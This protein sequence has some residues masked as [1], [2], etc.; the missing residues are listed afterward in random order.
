MHKCK[1][2]LLFWFLIAISQETIKSLLPSSWDK[3][4][5]VNIFRFKLRAKS[6][7]ICFY[8]IAYNKIYK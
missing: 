8:H 3:Q 5:S 2:L 6:M 1:R 7:I 4:I